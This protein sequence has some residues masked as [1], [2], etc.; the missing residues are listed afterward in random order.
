MEDVRAA[1]TAPG[2]VVVKV[3]SSSLTG[4]DGYLDEV[5]LV[6]LVDVLAG[7]RSRGQQV[8]LVTSGSIAAGLVPLGLSARPT[9][10]AT[11]QATASVG[12][13]LLIGAYA[14]AFARHALNVGQVL[15]TTDDLTRRA[16]YGNAQRALDRLLELG[17][18]PI[19][20]ENDT[21]ATD[22]IRF[23]DNDR[24]AALVATVVHAD[25]L[26]LLTDVDGLYTAAPGT[27]GA[28]R[29][30]SVGAFD[31]IEGV[32]ISQRGTT[33]GTG[34]MV[35][36]LEAARIATGSGV[37]VVLAAARDAAATV[38]GED[39]GTIFA[40]TGK[41]STN[42]LQWL[43]HSAKTRGQLVLDEG[44]VKAVRGGKASLLAAGVS[45]VRGEFE[46][47]D[48][49]ELV[50]PDGTAI[51]RGFARFAAY[52]IPAMLGLSTAAIRSTLG[53]EYAKE[54]V[55]VDDLVVVAT[56]K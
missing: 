30:A 38:A 12:Q 8:V 31:E 52:Q 7:M 40:P 19:V 37:V 54:L 33:L 18:V 27:P 53:E 41:R 47:G 6:A 48:P 50:G 56:G 51:A 15:L 20:N 3:G 11:A 25:A 16:H 43:A 35:T 5:G 10:L 23:G 24:L 39:V 49:V 13:G 17:V 1:L 42:R 44:A 55:H 22:E 9:D 21:V 2:R 45:A 26:V 32:D 36:K 29:I 14:R 4:A 46:A 34:G 28:R